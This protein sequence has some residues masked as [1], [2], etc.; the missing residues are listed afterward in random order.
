MIIRRRS[1]VSGAVVD[2]SAFRSEFPV[3]E[4]VAYFN[5]GS[6]GPVPRAAADAALGELRAGLERGRGGLPAFEHM[7]D[8]GDRLRQAAASLLG[9]EVAE[10][11]LTGATTDGVNA[12]VS[13]L[14]LGSG[15]EVLTSDEEHP[16]LLAPLA[17]GSARRGFTVRTVP[18]DE[19]AAEVGS[20]TRLVACSHVSWLNGKVADTAALAGADAMVLLDGAQGLGAVPARV[21]ELGCDF[22]A[23]SGQKWLCGPIGT[24]Y[25]FVAAER[26]DELAPAW[27]GYQSLE[28]P[29][30]ALELPLRAGAAR[31]D[32]TFP[33]GDRSAAAL[34]AIRTLQDA[35]LDDVHE[36]AAALADRLAGAL[37][38]RGLTVAPRGRS[39]LVSWETADNEAESRRLGEEG[40]VVR[41]LPGTAYVRASVGAWS[42]DEE[43]QR[44]VGAAA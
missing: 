6:I 23:A 8:L 1:L 13:G 38:E 39:T 33:A 16:G 30:R 12:V 44:L 29:T 7:R 10:V 20:A 36:R 21:R 32:V 2:A 34:A 35:G 28:E 27:P 5:T 9:C 40:I 22:Y 11:A 43:I 41:H 4:R 31:F 3:L 19:L 25:L 37:A 14:E 17:A 26:T 15:D 24:G 18:F 42:D